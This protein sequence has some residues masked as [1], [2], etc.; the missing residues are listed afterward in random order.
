M[1]YP[2]SLLKELCSIHAPSGSEYPVKKFLLEFIDKNSRDWRVKPEIL[3]GDDWQDSFALVFGDPKVAVYCHMDSI[4]YTVRYGNELVRIGGPHAEKGSKLCGEDKWGKIECSLDFD[5]DGSAIYQFE[6]EI[7]RGT[8]LTYWPNF[9]ETEE[10]VQCCYMDNRLGLFTMLNVCSNLENGVIV[11]SCWEEHGGGSAENAGR[12]LYENYKI[13]KSLIADITWVT[14]GVPMGKGVVVSIRDSGI[15][16]RSYVNRIIELATE[17]GIPFQVEVEG[18]GGSDGQSLQRS[19]YPIDWCFIGA[20]EDFVHSPNEMV[21]K[22]D[23]E[24]MI[25][26]Y[27]YLLISL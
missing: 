27:Q 11:F 10:T 2:Y 17:S 14:P 7:E 15:P 19:P 18:S 6:R 12:I 20:P 5:N 1:R 9:R 24:S 21:S 4:G 3:Q 22:A 25:S 26:L 13:R 8:T 23:I 16:R